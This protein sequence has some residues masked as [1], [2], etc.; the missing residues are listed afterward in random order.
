MSYQSSLEQAIRG[1]KVISFSYV[2]EGKQSGNRIGNPHALFYNKK[3][4][5]LCDIY[6]TSGATDEYDLPSWRQFT[7]E[8]IDRLSVSDASFSI[9]QGYNPSSD[10]YKDSIVQI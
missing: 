2:K 8:D 10:K 3:G 6:Q 4:D 1:R 9:A 5:V 7:V